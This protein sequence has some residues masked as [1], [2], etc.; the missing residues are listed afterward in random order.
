M[1]TNDIKLANG[2]QLTT[3]VD[4]GNKFVYYHTGTPQKRCPQCTDK[5]QERPTVVQ[6][7]ELLHKWT[8]IK[9]MSLPSTWET[10]NS[11]RS[12]EEDHYKI[13][14]KG[15]VFGAAWNGRIDIFASEKFKD[16]DIVDIREM[17]VQHLIKVVHEARNTMRHGQ[18]RVENEISVQETGEKTIRTRRYLVLER[19]ERC[20]GTEEKL[21]WAVADTKTT[22]SGLGRQYWAEVLDGACIASWMIS[23]GYRS[24]RASSTG[25][26]AIVSPEHPLFIQKTGDIEGEE[27]Y[28]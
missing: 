26:F 15:R 4:C 2:G 21:V 5:K 25:V 10:Q 11:G 13:T 9:I 18:V 6:R 3:C 1:T 16:G 20:L 7:R 28:K 17:E 8:G 22:L 24:G 23:G 12:H 27:C 14:I 19:A